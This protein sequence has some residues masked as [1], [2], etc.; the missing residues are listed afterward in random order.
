M[1]QLPLR[2]ITVLAEILRIR[3]Y[4]F[5]GKLLQSFLK[6][7]LVI[8]FTSY[9]AVWKVDG[10]VGTLLSCWIMKLRPQFRWLRS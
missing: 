5:V 1:S 3:E 7:S 9:L 6:F 2:L 4:T 10:T 8:H